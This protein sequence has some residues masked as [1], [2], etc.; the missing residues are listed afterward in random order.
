MSRE[1]YTCNRFKS[2]GSFQYARPIFPSRHPASAS[3]APTS[4]PR[5][6]DGRGWLAADPVSGRRCRLPRQCR[7]AH[8]RILQMTPAEFRAARTVPRPLR[9]PDGRTAGGAASPRAPD[10]TGREPS[11]SHNRIMP[12][13]REACATHT[14]WLPSQE[15]ARRRKRAYPFIVL[16]ALGASDSLPAI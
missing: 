8:R 6:L 9:Q 12:A 7:E 11:V 3:A 15:L 13:H 10:G 5:R 16:D 1:I 4:T 14:W 2:F